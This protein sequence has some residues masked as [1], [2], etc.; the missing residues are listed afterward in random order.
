MVSAGAGGPV[1]AAVPVFGS[2]DDDDED[3]RLKAALKPKEFKIPEFMKGFQEAVAA[4]AVDYDED[5]M[6]LPVAA[7]APKSAVSP[8]ELMTWD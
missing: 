7:S 3:A 4:K 5:G 2:L 6:P 8:M 1:A